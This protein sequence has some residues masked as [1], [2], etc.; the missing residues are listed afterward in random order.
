MPK[1][2]EP[3]GLVDSKSSSGICWKGMAESTP[4]DS[5]CRNPV[6][7]SNHTRSKRID[8]F[9]NATFIQILFKLLQGLPQS[10][11]HL[12]LEPP[13]RTLI[14]VVDAQLCIILVH[15]NVFSRMV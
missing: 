14:A 5:V 4:L 12:V 15:V 2:K 9:L 11:V 8:S 6:C 3:T 10:P 13:N 1:A 7:R